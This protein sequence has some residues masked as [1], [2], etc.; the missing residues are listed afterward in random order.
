MTAYDDTI[1]PKAHSS[2]NNTT[3]PPSKEGPQLLAPD[4]D[5]GRIIAGRY[6]LSKVLGRGGMGTVYLATHTTTGGAVAVKVLRAR[7][8]NQP[9][10]LER[11]ELEARNT[12]CLHHPNVVRVFDFGNDRGVLFL[13]MEYIPGRSL[14]AVLG[15]E[16]ALPWQR[17][18][19]ILEQVLMGLWAAHAHERQIVHRD[20]KPANILLTDHAGQ[21]DVVKVVDFGISHALM[22]TGGAQAT[23]IGSPQTMAPEQWMGQS[24]DVRTDLYAVGCTAY[25]MLSGKPPF[26]QPQL[27]ELRSAHLSTPPPPLSAHGGDGTIPAPLAAWVER[28]MAKDP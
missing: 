11:F 16:T 21:H 8:L 10:A 5:V 4:A 1:A 2:D 12:A 6:R 17:S 18:V 19:S 28:M 27:A 15:A 22:D 20:I 14:A 3:L 24:I 25:M 26:P 13:T 9:Q 7:L 23:P